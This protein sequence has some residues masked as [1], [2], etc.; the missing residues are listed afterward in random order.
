MQ[1][2]V[3]ILVFEEALGVQSGESWILYSELI[4][5]TR[6]TKLSKTDYI[7]LKVWGFQFKCCATLGI[8]S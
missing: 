7:R 3:L 5:K 1:S 6:I 8:V 2:D 4:F